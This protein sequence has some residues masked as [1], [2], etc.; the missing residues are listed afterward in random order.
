MDGTRPLLSHRQ[1]ELDGDVK[2]RR[3]SAYPI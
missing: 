1:I 3:R 2:L